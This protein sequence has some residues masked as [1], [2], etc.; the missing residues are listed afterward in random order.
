MAQVQEKTWFETHWGFAEG[1][2]VAADWIRDLEASDSRIHKE[3]VIEKAL[4][5][6]NLGSA[7]AQCFL[8]NAY[9]AYNP[10]FT[11]NV[12]KVPETQGL[13]QQENPW[14][15]FWGLLEGLRTRSITG[16][17]ARDRIQEISQRFDSSEWNGLARRVLI[18]DLRCGI[19]EKTLNKILKNTQWE[20]PVFTCQL[21]KDSADHEHKMTGRARLEIKLDGVRVITVIQ[22]RNVTMYSRNGKVFDNFGHLEDEIANILHKLRTRLSVSNNLAT[23]SSI[24]GQG[25]VL[26]GEVVG[27]SF[28]ELMRQAHRKSNVA[29]TDS[30]YY[31][32][33]W[34]PLE[35]FK[36]GHWNAQQHKRLAGLESVR[37]VLAEDSKLHILPGIEVDL[38]TAEGRD[39][40][41]RYAQDSVAGGYEGIMIK[42]LD[43]PYECKRSTFWMKWKPTITVDLNIVGF[44]EGTGR[45]EGRLGAIIC[46][47]VDNERN[48]RVNVG[49][50]LSDSDRDQYW[51]HRDRILGR[52]VEVMA[53]AVTQNQDG[54]YSLRFPRFVRFRGFEAGEKI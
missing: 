9:A 36:R 47:G 33:D 3:K 20:I 4:V 25:F 15:Q 31:I 40:T 12:K 44:E 19:S 14:T 52:V 1:V 54:S 50:G 30:H 28:Q 53:D 21:A 42:N 11:Y 18:K 35:D 46:E 2:A 27:R 6:A 23:G 29:A 16:H 41:R 45:N 38:D 13:T 43:A 10:F 37:E 24:F 34:L 8:M 51:I 26:D 49:S 32:F 5:A 39:Q 17:A 7:H 48:I 22:G